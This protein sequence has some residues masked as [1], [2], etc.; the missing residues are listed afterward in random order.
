MSDQSL[1]FETFARPTLLQQLAELP[2]TILNLSAAAGRTGVGFI[3]DR[4]GPVNALFIAVLMS[5]L[6]QLLIWTFVADYAG[7]VRTAT[8]RAFLST[9]PRKCSPV[10]SLARC[11]SPCSTG[12][13]AVAFCRCPPRSRPV[14]TAQVVWRGSLGCCSCSIFPVS[15]IVLTASRCVQLLQGNSTGAPIGGAI[16]TASGGSWKAVSI[17][18]GCTQIVGATILLYGGVCCFVRVT[19]FL[20]H[21]V[22]VDSSFQT[23]TQ[24]NGGVLTIAGLPRGE[25]RP[26]GWCYPT[27][28]G[29]C[30]V[31]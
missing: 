10:L 5:G 28:V 14:Y 18:S 27:A 7:I 1:S 4:I 9:L 21:A 25:L 20:M 31:E 11:H 13:S 2:L 19:L 16:L 23:G 8:R 6:T 3:A 17:Y 15:P 26:P 29:S 24:G 22:A 30:A 12:S